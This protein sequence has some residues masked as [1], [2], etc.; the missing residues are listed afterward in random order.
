MQIRPQYLNTN[1]ILYPQTTAERMLGKRQI[2]SRRRR[3]GMYRRRRR[4][5][6]P[7]EVPSASSLRRSIVGAFLRGTIP[8]ALTRDPRYGSEQRRKKIGRK[9]HGSEKHPEISSNG[10][11]KKWPR[12]NTVPTNS[13]HSSP[14]PNESQDTSINIQTPLPIP[15]PSIHIRFFVSLAPGVSIY[16]VKPSCNHDRS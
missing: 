15:S 7:A 12:T 16:A 13:I 8:T 9:R 2:F 11:D 4:Q 3:Y 10:M 14:L 1:T 6:L 5:R